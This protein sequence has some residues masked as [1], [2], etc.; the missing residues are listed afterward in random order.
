MPLPSKEGLDNPSMISNQTDKIECD[1]TT[2]IIIYT[3]M[4]V[5]IDNNLP[6]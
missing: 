2:V 5:V 3:P 1:S 6:I 4:A